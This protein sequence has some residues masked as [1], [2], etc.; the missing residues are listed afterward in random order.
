MPDRP[1]SQPKSGMPMR[2]GSAAP[3]FSSRRRARLA[4]RCGDGS[5]DPI[6][7]LSRGRET[8]SSVAIFV[9]T[10]PGV[11]NV[12]AQTLFA[13]GFALVKVDEIWLE[14]GL[15]APGGDVIICGRFQGLSLPHT[16]CEPASLQ[17]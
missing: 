15:T 16:C 7:G 14:K 1:P 17:A 6:I 8:W 12:F 5:L 11:S 10:M 13:Y 9:S 3:S 2:M 4:A